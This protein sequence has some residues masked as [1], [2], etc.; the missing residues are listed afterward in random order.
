MIAGDALT[1][2]VP[3]GGSGA[4]VG[5]VLAASLV[6]APGVRGVGIDVVAVERFAAALHRTPALAPR[7]FAAAERV[8]GSGH[9]R[10]PASLAARFAVKEAVAKA[11][12][13]PA[14]MDWHDC[15]V[16]SES[17][18]R[19][20]LRVTGTVASAALA[21]GITDWRIS[22]SHDAGI[23]AAIVVGLG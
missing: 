12:G 4:A 2:A 14:G 16:L 3:S 10:S 13:V 1:V 7:L 21:L 6:S 20:V 19:P 22:L 9:P 15:S 11:L 17:S 5:A 23:A 8:T 18:G